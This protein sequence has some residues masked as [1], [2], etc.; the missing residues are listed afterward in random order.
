LSLIFSS[1]KKKNCKK[2]SAR[3]Q[4]VPTY[5]YY[6]PSKKYSSRDTVP[7]T[8]GL[9]EA[10]VRIRV[11]EESLAKATRAIDRS[12]KAQEVQ[13]LIKENSFLQEKL[14]FQACRTAVLVDFLNLLTELCTWY[15]CCGTM[16]FWF[17]S[18]SAD[19]C[20]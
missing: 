3:V 13:Q 2:L 17:G 10:T 12:K 9:A 19:P 11:L 4:N 18:G 6:K 15:Q 7:L 5:Y 8:A 16:T 14:A 20:L 1:K